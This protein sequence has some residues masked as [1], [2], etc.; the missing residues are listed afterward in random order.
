MAIRDELA[1]AEKKLDAIRAE[2]EVTDVRIL[3]GRILE[4]L[5]GP[6]GG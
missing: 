6:A 4:I 1:D 5:D 2:V 3:R